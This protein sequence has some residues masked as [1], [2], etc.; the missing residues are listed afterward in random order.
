MFDILDPVR[1]AFM[2]WIVSEKN[3]NHARFN[4]QKYFEYAFCDISE[5]HLKDTY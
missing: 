2:I 1:A 4:G 5:F 3:K